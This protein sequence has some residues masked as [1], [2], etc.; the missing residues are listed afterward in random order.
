MISFVRKYILG[1][2]DTSEY[3]PHIFIVLCF[4]L[5]AS[6]VYAGTADQ[7]RG[8]LPMR[9]VFSF[10]VISSFL[11][12]ERIRIDADLRALFSPLI[13]AAATTIWAIFFGDFL[14]Y[15]AAIGCAVISLTHLKP[16]ALGVYLITI[17]AFQAVLLV[18][19]GQSLLGNNFTWAQNLVGLLTSLSINAV[20]YTFC[21]HYASLLAALTEA[22]NEASAAAV[23]K[24]EFL[25][26]M[27]HEIR[28]PLNAVIGMTAVG[29]TAKDIPSA[30][31][32]FNK[33]EEASSHL[34]RIVNDVLD[35]AKLESGKLEF[36]YRNFT[37]SRTIKRVASI[38][39][40]EIERKEQRFRY[41]IDED[42]PSL[43]S[44][45]EQRLTQVLLNLFGN[46]VKFTPENGKIQ[47]NAR[48]V[49]EVD[50]ICTIEVKVTDSGIGISAVQ[51]A[52]LFKVFFQ[53]EANI[54]QRF[55]GTG[56]GLAISKN[57][58]EKMGGTIWVDSKMGEGTSFTFTVQLARGIYTEN[59]AD[60]DPEAEPADYSNLRVLLAEDIEVNREIMLALLESTGLQ[61]V[62]AANGEQA[63]AIFSNSPE[64]F[65]LIFMDVQMPEMDG[66]AATRAIR[67]L[68]N[69]PKAKTIPI[70]AMTANVLSEDIQ[71]CLEAGMDKHIG[72]PIDINEI[73]KALSSL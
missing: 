65:D 15:T 13:I 38:M 34:L 63:V 68:K 73:H 51:Q 16:K 7:H 26:N 69:T 40:P 11:I 4:Y 70:V 43:L 54:S 62:C 39:T 20:L 28:T 10:V 32:S 22:K 67:A 41:Y 27:S 3:A 55:G 33:I 9:I 24:G 21:V 64:D 45:D 31:Y 37:L 12:L 53:A 2:S 59:T 17:A 1:N 56:L 36:L 72:K 61:I 25:S 19:P 52:N 29:K 46:A 14:V 44:G 57:I 18:L 30:K 5:A 47:L 66:Y 35:M 42:L 8:V 58:V 23:A 71:K 6:L 49:R 48:L 60:D 50:N